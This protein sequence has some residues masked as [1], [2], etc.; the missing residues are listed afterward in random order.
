MLSAGAEVRRRLA[1]CLLRPVTLPQSANKQLAP[2]LYTA[3]L[4]PNGLF[5]LP[6]P[7]PHSPFPIPHSLV[8]VQRVEQIS[9]EF[10]RVLLPVHRVFFQGAEY[11]GFDHEVHFRIERA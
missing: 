8:Q 7:T 4:L 3:K 6:L 2:H 5:K 9:S 10:Q 1:S 11:L